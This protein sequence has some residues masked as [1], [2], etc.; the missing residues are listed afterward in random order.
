M[1][2]IRIMYLAIKPLAGGGYGYYWQPSPA[3]TKAGWEAE[4]Y[5][6]SIRPD[7]SEKLDQAR[8][9][10]EQV[11]AWRNGGAKPR[12]VKQFV[13][14]NTVAQLIQ[15][16][17]EHIEERVAQGK[18]PPK[19]RDPTRGKPMSENTRDEYF[20]KLKI[21]KIWATDPK[22]KGGDG[23]FLIANI[24]PERVEKLR[25]GLMKPDPETGEIK[26]HRAHGTLRV[27]RSMFSYAEKQKIIPKGSNPA[28]DFGLEA[29]P[30]RD[31]VWDVGGGNG[32]TEALIKAAELIGFPSL[33]L[34]HELAEWTG[35]RQADILKL[36]ENHWETIRLPDQA[37]VD[38]LRGDDEELKGFVVTQNK[39]RASGGRG[40]TLSLP[41]VQP[42]RAKVEAAIAANRA[43]PV[44]A[45]TILVC[46]STG[47]P[48][49]R[50]HFTKMFA[51]A[52]ELAINPTTPEAI[53]AG[54]VARPSLADLQYRDLRRTRVVRLAERGIDAIGI[55]SIT[56]HSIKTIEKMLDEVY[57]PR[58]TRQAA[59][60]YL[61]AN[62]PSPRAADQKGK[63]RA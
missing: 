15:S 40:K 32:D 30:S 25:D 54:L 36:T 46:E 42:I 61:T 19:M 28:Q 41:I 8:A 1:A 13:E 9:R 29:P 62:G 27:L 16:Y 44:P 18:L 38:A 35:Q 45:T 5:G 17:K 33:G 2:N 55:A 37:L 12:E 4:N 10:N 60:A 51:R 23:N 53:A 59:I 50:W 11:K 26:W 34:A 49:K 43:R 31:Q 7:D 22:K 47:R 63:K 24:T 6:I 57:R 56:G 21:I 58:T 20:G 48:W 14:R 39:S 52:R 3:L